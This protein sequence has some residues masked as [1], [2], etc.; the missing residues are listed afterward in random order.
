MTPTPPRWAD[1]LLRAS[2][3]PADVNSVSG[4]LLEDYRDTLYPAKGQAGA[5]AWYVVQVLGYVLRNARAWGLLLAVAFLARTALDWLAPPVGLHALFARSVVSTWFA[6][7][8]LLSLGLWAS[9]RAGSFLAG[10]F[11]GIAGTAIGAVISVV[12][13]VGLLA[14]WHDPATMAAIRSTGGLGEVFEL[15]VMMI[16]PGAV[17]GAVGGALGVTLNRFRAA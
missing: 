6:V 1:A 17:L 13:A 9:M 7:G 11:A 16:L 8:L 15:P 4:D 5:D 10:T 12:G 3:K 2:L 14:V